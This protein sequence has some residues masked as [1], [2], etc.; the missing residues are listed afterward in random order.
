MLTGQFTWRRQIRLNYQST[1]SL[2][3]GM[4]TMDV[5]RVGT[6][7]SFQKICKGKKVDC[8]FSIRRGIP[9]A[10]SVPEIRVS[11]MIAKPCDYVHL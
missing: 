3:Y 4:A 7:R 9:R 6:I 10:W 11:L 2:T 8:A 1:E 5:S